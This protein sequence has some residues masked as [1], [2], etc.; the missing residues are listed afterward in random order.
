MPRE[1]FVQPEQLADA[2]AW[3]VN[4]PDTVQVEE[5]IIRPTDK[6]W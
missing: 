1:K 4:L 3:I 5:I 6:N 2:L